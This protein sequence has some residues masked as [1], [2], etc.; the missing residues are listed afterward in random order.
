MLH[1]FC[2]D[3]SSVF[4][5]FYKCFR[6]MFQMFFCLYTYVANVLS[7]CFKSRSGV[8]RI[9][10]A[11]VAD[12]QQPAAWLRLL[13]RAFLARRV[14]PSPLLFLPSLPFPPSRRGSSISEALPKEL[15]DPRRCGGS[16]WADGGVMPVWWRPRSTLRSMPFA[17][18]HG[19]PNA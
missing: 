12:G 3:F 19:R 14:S 17:R 2:N 4:R 16:E 7:G 6:C 9:V 11:P 13:P 15:T 10:M 8:A 18:S 1:M 5:C